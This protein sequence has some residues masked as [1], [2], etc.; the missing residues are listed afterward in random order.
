MTVD[1]DSVRKALSSGDRQQ[2]VSAGQAAVEMED[3]GRW[4]LAVLAEGIN[5]NY[6]KDALG[7]Y[8]KDIGA[9]SPKLREY[10]SVWR[11]AR[12]V[13]GAEFLTDYPAVNYSMWR[14][15][16]RLAKDIDKAKA[17]L[18][19]AANE[20]LSPDATKVEVEKAGGGTIHEKILDIETRNWSYGTT[21]LEF[22]HDGITEA[23]EALRKAENIRIV[24]YDA[25]EGETQEGAVLEEIE[26]VVP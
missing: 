14:Q 7:E 2:M 5:K 21:R 6:G 24:I 26:G 23:L 25:N 4:T 16:A 12:K 8:A 1:F 17:L 10:R 13:A 15:I 11:G 18:E 3:A 19:K 22:V 20:K 9:P